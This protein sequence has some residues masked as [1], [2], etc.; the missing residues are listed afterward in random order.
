MRGVS[1][2]RQKSGQSTFFSYGNAYAE[3]ILR[4]G[5]EKGEERSGDYGRALR[6]T[7]DA[8][9]PGPKGLCAG[10]RPLPRSSRGLRRST[11]VTASLFASRLADPG[12]NPGL[13]RTQRRRFHMRRTCSIPLPTPAQRLASIDSQNREPRW[14]ARP[15]IV[16]IGL[17][18]AEGSG[19][20]TYQ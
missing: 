11:D 18:S 2:A 14:R 16:I 1:T 3:G 15:I 6:Q 5:Q 7:R 12:F 9:A 17:D 8:K 19:E 4:H 10:G 20:I 13:A